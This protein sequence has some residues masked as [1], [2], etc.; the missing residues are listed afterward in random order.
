MV[1]L[2]RRSELEKRIVGK[3][4]KVTY[5]KTKGNCLYTAVKIGNVKKVTKYDISIVFDNGHSLPRS[6]ISNIEVLD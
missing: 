1:T 2:D 3:K 6:Q 4:C 5:T